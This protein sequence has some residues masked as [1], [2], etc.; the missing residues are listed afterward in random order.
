[1]GVSTYLFFETIKHLII[2][3][4]SMFLILSI[5]SLMANFKAVDKYKQIVS[6]EVQESQGVTSG[7]L[8]FALGPRAL[9][10]DMQLSS[11]AQTNQNISQADAYAEDT[12]SNQ[13]WLGLAM[14]ILWIGIFS[15]IKYQE[16][17]AQ[18]YVD[19]ES[20]TASDFTL[21]FE[22]MPESMT[23]EEL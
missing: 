15:W 1:M 14:L 9:S 19:Y 13:C 12:F 20:W 17:Q 22:N 18:L 4:I 10:S 21:K 8:A 23:K 7:I 5:Y 11:D 16:R 3:L 2:L 6:A